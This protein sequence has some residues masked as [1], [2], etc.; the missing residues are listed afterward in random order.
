MDSLTQAALGAVVMEATAGKKL[1]N[2]ALLWGLWFGTLPDLDIVLY[3]LLDP[4]QQLGWHRGLSHSLVLMTATAPLWG[5]L[6]ARLHRG[7][8]GWQPAAWAV[9]WVLF[10]H[11][12]IDCFTVYGTQIFEPFSHLRVGLNNLFIIDP[13]FTAPLVLAL[14][15]VPWFRLQGGRSA[16]RGRLTWTALALSSLYTFWS[17]GA[18]AVAHQRVTAALEARAI[19]HTRLM[20]TPTLLNTFLWRALVDT[21]EAYLVAYTSL[22]DKP[23]TP[24]RFERLPKNQQALGEAAGSRAAETLAWFSQGWWT[25]VPG[26]DGPLIYDWRFGELRHPGPLGPDNPPVPIFAWQLRRENGNWIP[27]QVRL[28]GP[29]RRD[30]LGPVWRRL[31][32]EP[33]F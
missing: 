19:P 12:L 10:T 13:L 25:A 9:W 20:T 14:L 33:V 4:V 11:V 29:Q 31:K 32:G 26:P 18:K 24:L 5:L 22:L 8:I 7:A 27:V 16:W 28:P 21:E 2:K 23:G 3:P 30:L 6:L 15:L 1:G 17:F